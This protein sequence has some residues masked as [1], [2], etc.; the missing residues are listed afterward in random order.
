MRTTLAV[1]V[2]TALS[3]LLCTSLPAQTTYRLKPVDSVCVAPNSTTIWRDNRH[4]AYTGSGT[5]NQLDIRGLLKFDLT[6]IPDRASV[7]SM[8]L[9]CTL[10]NR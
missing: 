9:T 2:L 1:A 3:S 7:V 4:R 8:K 6:I 10:E 5:T